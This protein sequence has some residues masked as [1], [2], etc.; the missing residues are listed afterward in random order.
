VQKLRC[1]EVD[2]FDRDVWEAAQ[3][4]TRS[5]VCGGVPVRGS[6][7]VMSTMHRPYGL[8]HELAGVGA[9]SRRLIRWCALDVMGECRS[10]EPCES[11]VLGD[12]CGGRARG[13]RGFLG[14]QD[15]LE[16]R[17]R[18]SRTRFASEMLCVKPSRSDAVFAMFDPAR[19][20][21]EFE[22]DLAL[23]WI[24]G[25]DFGMRDPFVMLWAQVR[26]TPRGDRVEVID[27]HLRADCTVAEHLKE[28]ASRPW[29]APRWIGVDPAGAQRSS[30]TG[31]STIGVLRAAGH[32]IKAAR[33]PIERG[34][35]VIRR[36]LEGPA[37]PV[38]S[39]GTG[40]EA[41][42]PSLRIHPR[43]RQLIAA[44]SGYHFD[45]DRPHDPLPVKDGH[46]HAV[47]ALRYML[48]NLEEATGAPLRASDY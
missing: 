30:H 34:L 31:Q 13:W 6:I 11:C 14:A 17:R 29:P 32:R 16:Q 33:W 12:E 25:M 37:G 20:V 22:P 27:E 46:D 38:E 8:M 21:A 36:R 41:A 4:V 28:M 40:G 35:E 19:H 43:C 7:E 9:G 48:I 24:G 39:G 1:D 23:R 2:L 3:F 44:L 10:P 15:V 42:G 5:A 26:L 45:A 18:C 47:D